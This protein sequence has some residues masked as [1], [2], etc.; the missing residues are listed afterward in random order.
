MNEL[1]KIKDVSIL[2][3]VTTRTLR[4]YEKMGL[5]NSSRDESSGYRLYD[6]TALIRLKQILILRKMSISIDDIGRIFSSK[7]SDTVLTVL[8]KK[9]DDIDNEMALLH[10]LKEFVLE[11]IHQIRQVDFHNDT[12]I[13]KLYDKAQQLEIALTEDSKLEQLLD[14]SDELDPTMTSLIIEPTPGE[15]KVDKSKI[16]LQN[17]E[18]VKMEARRFIGKAIYGHAI[19][20]YNTYAEDEMPS[21]IMFGDLW[22]HKNWISSKLDAI[23][24]YATEDVHYIGLTTWEKYDPDHNHLQGYWVGRFM[25]ADT[26]VPKGLDYLDFPEMYVAKGVAKGEINIVEKRSTGEFF[27]EINHGSILVRNEMKRQGKYNFN[28]AFEAE[29]YTESPNGEGDIFGWENWLSCNPIK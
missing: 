23:S 21:G 28:G 24:E 5:I 7:N 11:F 22:R 26:P 14:T 10:E 3:N 29:V 15:R 17:Y 1:T 12:D 20:D 2:Y 18:V 6:E 13:K 16:S 27:V 25:K 8:D 19:F 9:V 4:Y